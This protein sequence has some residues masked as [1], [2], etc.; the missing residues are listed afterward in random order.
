MTNDRHD[1]ITK[2]VTDAWDFWLSQ[3]D[4]TVPDTIEAAVS[5]ATR[6]WLDGHT[7]ELIEAI[8]KAVADRWEEN[9]R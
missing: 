7:P 8:A 4:V 3:H 5:T 6:A 9:N 1:A 2:G